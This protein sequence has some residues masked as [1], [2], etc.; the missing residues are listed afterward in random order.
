MKKKVLLVLVLIMPIICNAKEEV[1]YR[2][3]NYEE[4]NVHYVSE[5]ESVC[6]YFDKSDYKYTDYVY[7]LT[8]PEVKEGREITSDYKDYTF[9]RK[10]VNKIG[11]TRFSGATEYDFYELEVLD[12]DGN[13]VPYEFKSYLDNYL[14]LKDKDYNNAARILMYVNMDIVF[15]S[16]IDIENTSIR[17]T[18]KNVKGELNGIDFKAYMTDEYVSNSYAGYSTINTHVCNNEKCVFTAKIDKRQMSTTDVVV[19]T[20]VY[21]YRDTLYKCYDMVK[22]YAPGYYENLSGYTKDEKDYIV[23]NS[24]T[25]EE[26]DKIIS[27]NMNLVSEQ[28]KELI[29]EVMKLKSELNNKDDILKKMAEFEKLVKSTSEDNTDMLGKLA[30]LETLIKNDNISYESVINKLSELDS[31][32]SNFD[33]TELKD[34]ITKASQKEDNT[35]KKVSNTNTENKE[36][37]EKIAF[38]TRKDESVPVKTNMFILVFG[39]MSLLVSLVV[40]IKN[41]VKCRKK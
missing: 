17:I 11:I 7:S 35:V 40:L 37:K 9:L 25:T 30:S 6:E 13:S 2:W 41:V 19:K 27:E 26:I 18:Y 15:D 38:V 1:K 16:P 3:Y 28:N 23:T 5:P 4:S 29:S 39:V 36:T 22:N 34:F 21:K 12:K 33:M 10:Y 32:N 20:K 14:L 8:S 24:L 31:K